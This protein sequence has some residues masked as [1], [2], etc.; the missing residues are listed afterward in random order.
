MIIST[1]HECFDTTVRFNLTK[2]FS[3]SKAFDL[4]HARQRETMRH[5][6][7][8]QDTQKTITRDNAMWQTVAVMNRIS[9]HDDFHWFDINSWQFASLIDGRNFFIGLYLSCRGDE[10]NCTF[11]YFVSFQLYSAPWEKSFNW[12]AWK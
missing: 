8:P 2:S 3:Q 1:R 10:V 5:K 7:F 6:L 4:K 9:R 11:C 12:V